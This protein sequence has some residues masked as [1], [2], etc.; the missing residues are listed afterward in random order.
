MDLSGKFKLYDVCVDAV[1][2]IIVPCTKIKPLAVNTRTDLAICQLPDDNNLPLIPLE[3]GGAFL[4]LNSYCFNHISVFFS[5]MA[6]YSSFSRM[7]SELKRVVLSYSSRPIA[8][9]IEFDFSKTIKKAM[10]GFAHIRLKGY[11]VE[12]GVWQPVR[13]YATAFCFYPGLIATNCDTVCSEDLS[14]KFHLYDVCV[15]AVN[16]IIVPRTR[17]KPLAIDTSTDLAILQLPDDNKL[18]LIPLELG[19]GSRC[20]VGERIF[21]ISHASYKEVKIFLPNPAKV[22][23]NFRYIQSGLGIRC[24]MSGLPVINTSGQ[25]IGIYS[26]AIMS[27][28]KVSR[29]IYSDYLFELISWL[30][31]NEKVFGTRISSIYHPSRRC[32]EVNI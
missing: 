2:Q 29:E 13:G 32:N 17:V 4:N 11:K 3:L 30:A 31:M 16:Q 12:D 28:P 6:A 27:Q 22:P 25:V 7:S 19:L 26:S 21:A 8:R 23:S 5:D 1:N 18:P 14:R 20:R 15:N 9:T 24:G 10:P